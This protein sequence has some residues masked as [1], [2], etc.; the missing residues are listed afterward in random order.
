MPDQTTKTP[1]TE[2]LTA[3]EEALSAREQSAA[4][5]EKALRAQEV[6][7]AEREEKHLKAQAEKDAASALDFAEDQVERGVIPP[8]QKAKFA[9]FMASLDPEE[10]VT[11]TGKDG[12][13][14]S[15][16]Q[17]VAFR[18]LMAGVGEY[19]SPAAPDSGDNIKIG[20]THWQID[21]DRRVLDQEI[22]SY[23]EKEGVTYEAAF[24]AVAS[25]GR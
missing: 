15:V 18:E 19:T 9:L 8:G 11:H 5:R 21:P 10:M 2:D 17:T 22:R 20:G 3:Q 6:A 13:E 25:R 4:A 16:P 14:V 12:K 23:A 7:F 24:T 1:T